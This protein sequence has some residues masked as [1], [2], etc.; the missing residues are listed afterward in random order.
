MSVLSLPR[1]F[2]IE[3]WPVESEAARKELQ[4]IKAAATHDIIPLPA[5]DVNGKLIRP[6]DYR[7]LL[8]GAVVEVHFTLTHWTIASR[9]GD[10]P[11]DTYVADVQYMRVLVPAPPSLPRKRCISLTDPLSSPSKK[12]R[13]T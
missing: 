1:E 7:H 6:Q 5:Y 2:T 10:P 11:A 4:A 8:A 13:T 12:Q 3:A 9:R